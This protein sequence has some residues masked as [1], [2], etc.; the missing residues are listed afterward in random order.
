MRALAQINAAGDEA[1]ERAVMEETARDA[2]C[3][4]MPY[5]RHKRTE[6][7]NCTVDR[8]KRRSGTDAW[9]VRARCAR[10]G[11]NTTSKNVAQTLGRGHEDV[12]SAAHAFEGDH[13]GT[14]FNRRVI[15]K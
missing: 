9:T 5:I 14:E 11:S 15:A 7:R 12:A 10:S 8:C 3:G 1:S 4:S 2:V 13:S 6:G